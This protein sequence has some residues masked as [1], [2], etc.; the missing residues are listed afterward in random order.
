MK[1]NLI[2]YICP[3]SSNND[4][5]MNIDFL[6]KYIDVFNHKKIIT[7]SSGGNMTD[8]QDVV[9]YF[10]DKNA[11]FIKIQNDQKLGE[12]IPFMEMMK[13]IKSFDK[14]EITFYAH[15]KGVSPR[16]HNNNQKKLNNKRIWRNFLYHF[17]LN[18]VERVDEVLKNHT[19]CGCI[20]RNFKLGDTNAKWFYAGNFFWFNNEKI[21][22]NPNWNVIR[23]NRMG[24]EGYMGEKYI[25]STGCGL[26]GDDLP[27]NIINFEH[28]WRD[29]FKN[30]NMEWDFLKI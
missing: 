6:K 21:F 26:F 16:Y 8:F 1:R 15:T 29:Y 4:W 23:L 7:V 11:T 10:D 28:Q 30:K 19:S 24:V 22:S 18:D 3:I 20:K 9:D 2:Y 17:N 14:D 13:K 12:V 5:K 27:T 25:S